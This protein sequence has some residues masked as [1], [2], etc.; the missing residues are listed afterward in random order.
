[1]Y[2]KLIKLVTKHKLKLNKNIKKL[3]KIAKT[4]KLL[5]LKINSNV[6]W[7]HRNKSIYK[8]KNTILVYK[9]Y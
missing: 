4:T 2:I 3:I 5:K 8:Y 1:M 7:N 9:Q 6:N